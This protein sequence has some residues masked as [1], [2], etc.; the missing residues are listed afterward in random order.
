MESLEPYLTLRN[1]VVAAA[2]LFAFFLVR[3]LFARSPQSKY[4]VPALC[5]SCGWVGSAS[6]FN[7]KC[8]KCASPIGGAP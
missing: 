6:K 4:A 3:R 2:L 1:A 7:A 8:P 5:T